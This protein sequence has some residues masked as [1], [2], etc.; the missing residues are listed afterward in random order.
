MSHIF[1]YVI[2]SNKIKFS[3]VEH[4]R[5][6]Q[7]TGSFSLAILLRVIVDFDNF[8]S[9]DKAH[10]NSEQ[11]SCLFICFTEIDENL[12]WKYTHCF[13]F[14]FLWI[15]QG[16]VPT[17]VCKVSKLHDIPDTKTTVFGYVTAK[18]MVAHINHPIP[19][20]LNLGVWFFLECQVSENCCSP[21]PDKSALYFALWP[22]VVYTHTAPVWLPLSILLRRR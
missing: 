15:H 3:Q 5:Q 4:W 7:V 12:E 18:I 20:G 2:P 1:S 21:W 17:A 13:A 8:V 10:T 22:N 6:R 19:N 14:F 9:R 16:A 11:R